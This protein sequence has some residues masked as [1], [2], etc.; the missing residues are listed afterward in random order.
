MD[1]WASR[2]DSGPPHLTGPDTLA[3]ESPTKAPWNAAAER[4]AAS[5]RRMGNPAANQPPGRA[6]LSPEWTLPLCAQLMAGRA[7]VAPLL[8]PFKEKGAIVWISQSEHSWKEENGVSLT[9]L[10][11]EAEAAIRLHSEYMKLLCVGARQPR[12]PRSPAD[13][14][15]SGNV[16]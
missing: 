9:A 11:K 12:R 1:L 15:Y 3:R 10:F 5:P 8:P 16:Q 2:G 4:A 7:A 14:L 13:S 6:P